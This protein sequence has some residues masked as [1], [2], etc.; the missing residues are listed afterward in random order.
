[1]DTPLQR[2]ISGFRSLVESVEAAADRGPKA[3]LARF[4]L[5]GLSATLAQIATEGVPSAVSDGLD[6]VRSFV[7]SSGGADR[8]EGARLRDKVQAYALVAD[9]LGL[10]TEELLDL[11]RRWD[12][13][14]AP[15]PAR[16][17]TG[18]RS[19]STRPARE[20]TA[21]TAGD[22]ECPVCGVRFKRVAKHMSSAHP[23]EWARRKGG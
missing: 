19:A 23:E 15:A 1:V 20:R 2:T 16:S 3:E 7:E 14:T 21:G 9:D 22:Q 5:Q 17:G 8:A 18:R 13:A 6:A 4:Q 10:D 12:A 11:V